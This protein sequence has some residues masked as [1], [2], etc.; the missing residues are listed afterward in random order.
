VPFLEE[1]LEYDRAV[2]ATALDR[3]EYLISFRS[4]PMPRPMRRF[5]QV[6]H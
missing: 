3:N 1:V 6:I 5:L 4:A 2:M